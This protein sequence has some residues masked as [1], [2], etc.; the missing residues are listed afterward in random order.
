M[1]QVLGVLHCDSIQ[2]TRAKTGLDQYSS[3]RNV[4]LSSGLIPESIG[5][6]KLRD[7]VDFFFFCISYYQKFVLSGNK[8]IFRYQQLK[9]HT[10]QRGNRY[11]T[12]DFFGQLV[13]QSVCV[14][15]SYKHKTWIIV[16]NGSTT[17]QPRVLQHLFTQLC[18]HQQ[19]T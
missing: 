2:K 8:C 7:D 18:L 16:A 12:V 14:R 19:I 15:L 4:D 3:T 6:R 1:V 17:Q 10:A 11:F 5:C 13:Q 9:L